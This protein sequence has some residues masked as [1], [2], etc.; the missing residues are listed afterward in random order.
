MQ[1]IVQFTISGF[2]AWKADYDAHIEDR[3]TAGLTMLQMWR[4]ADDANRVAVLYEAHDRAR[5][6]QWFKQQ[7]A[8]KGATSAQFLKTA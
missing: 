7:A 2:D 1:L 3:D 4:D 5:A 8:L 6:D